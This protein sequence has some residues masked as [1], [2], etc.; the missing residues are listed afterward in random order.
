V[1]EMKRDRAQ[2]DPLFLPLPHVVRESC[3]KEAYVSDLMS[4]EL[5]FLFH[6]LPERAVRR[7]HLC[8][9]RCPKSYPKEGQGCGKWGE[10]TD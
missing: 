8:P 6:M 1:L 4:E 7:R 5:S 10:A 2:P 3:P 9:I